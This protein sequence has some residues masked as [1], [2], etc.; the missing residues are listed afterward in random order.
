V[1]I[2]PGQQR[3]EEY[4]TRDEK[5][6]RFLLDEFLPNVVLNTYD[7]V[8]DPNGWL[9]GGHSSGGGC[10]FN[11][12]WFNVDKFHKIVT[13]NGTFVGLQDPGNDDYIELVTQEALKPLRV[14][15][16]SGTNDLGGD[17]WFNANNDMS[18]SLMEAGYPYRYMK[19]TTSH[20]LQPWA[21]GGFPDTL[22][23]IWRGYSLP[24]YEV[25]P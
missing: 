11:A 1:F 3:S 18:A 15:L 2:E 4:D 10:A 17:T 5:Y 19:S 16:H 8:D 14:T 24:H 7:I 9:I 13:H 25:V 20:D 22:R 21:S 12:A 6:G 23:W